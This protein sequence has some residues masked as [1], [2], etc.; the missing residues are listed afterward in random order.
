MMLPRY[1]E[2]LDVRTSAPPSRIVAGSH[3]GPDENCAALSGT[4]SRSSDAIHGATAWINKRTRSSLSKIGSE[5]ETD[6]RRLE[7][8]RWSTLDNRPPA[9]LN[10]PRQSRDRTKRVNSRKRN[11]R[12]CSK[13]SAS[14]RLFHPFDSSA[15]TIIKVSIAQKPAISRPIAWRRSAAA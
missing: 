1:L 13:P 3:P 4:G 15:E 5:A 7:E 8:S 10:K 2:D 11:R 12:Y 9:S 14:A 6:G